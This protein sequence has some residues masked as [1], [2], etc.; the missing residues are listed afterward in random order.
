MQL[1]R[2]HRKEFVSVHAGRGFSLV[3]NKKLLFY[4]LI[5]LI[6]NDFMNSECNL[7]RKVTL[8]HQKLLDF[9]AKV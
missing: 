6:C 1:G 7:V 8:L 5:T 3:V 9:P 4:N 2:F